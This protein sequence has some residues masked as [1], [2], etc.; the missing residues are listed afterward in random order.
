MSVLFLRQQQPKN[1]KNGL[2]IVQERASLIILIKI[3]TEDVTVLLTACL[4]FLRLSG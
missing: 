2:L 1:P 4:A 3:G